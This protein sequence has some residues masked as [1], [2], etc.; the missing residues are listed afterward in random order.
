VFLGSSS[1]NPFRIHQEPPLTSGAFSC[2]R[3][4]VHSPRKGVGAD[5]G[6]CLRACVRLANRHPRDLVP[7]CRSAEC[8]A[9]AGFPAQHVTHVRVYLDA[10]SPRVSGGEDSIP[11]V[12]SSGCLLRMALEPLPV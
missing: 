4:Q 11:I 1:S 8:H 3:P 10:E 9:G 7:L 6:A 2:P 5:F 12:G